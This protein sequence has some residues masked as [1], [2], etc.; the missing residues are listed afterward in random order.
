MSWLLSGWHQELATNSGRRQNASYL[1]PEIIYP[2]ALCL[3]ID[4]NKLT[5]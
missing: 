2:K 3:L 1:S 5:I 4:I